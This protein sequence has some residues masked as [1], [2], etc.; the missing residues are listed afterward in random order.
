[1]DGLKMAQHHHPINAAAMAKGLFGALTA[2]GAA[3]GLAVDPRSLAMAAAF[4]QQPSVLHHQH[5]FHHHQV[6]Q[7]AAAAAALHH[8]VGFHHHLQQVGDNRNPALNGSIR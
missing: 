4:L 1:M 2:A 3:N 7:A 8:H 5:P 6:Q